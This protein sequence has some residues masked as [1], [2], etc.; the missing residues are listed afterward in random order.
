[1]D[2]ATSKAVGHPYQRPLIPRLGP[3][4]LVAER[5][6]EMIKVSAAGCGGTPDEVGAAAAYLMGPD[7]G[8]MV[9]GQR[10]RSGRPG[11]RRTCMSPTE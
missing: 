5:Y 1:V 9:P 4:R 11:S 3:P 8:L 7:G 10:S 2:D 6:R